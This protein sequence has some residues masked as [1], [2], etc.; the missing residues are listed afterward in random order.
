MPD[1]VIICVVALALSLASVASAQTSSTRGA[2]FPDGHR[3]ANQSV[4]LTASVVSALE[5]SSVAGIA[6]E[7]NTAVAYSGRRNRLTL[8]ASAA[9]FVRRDANYFMSSGVDFN[10]TRRTTLHAQGGAS[11]APYFTLTPF[12]GGPSGGF[13]D[14]TPQDS[15]F[16]VLPGQIRSTGAGASMTTR[17]TD[18]VT[19]TIGTSLRRTAS[20]DG[21]VVFGE[22]G[23]TSQFGRGLGRRAHLHIGYAY[24][25]GYYRTAT[26]PRTVRDHD[27]DVG[28]G[29]AWR[30]SRSRQTTIEGAA[31][32]TR[33]DLEG[34]L[35]YL[36]TGSVNL[37]RQLNKTWSATATYRRGMESITA[38]GHAPF[39]NAVSATVTGHIKD[40]L[41][42]DLT[43]GRS[44]G[45]IGFEA[46]DNRYDTYSAS[47]RLA[48]AVRPG[49][50]VYG[51][52]FHYGFSF[53]NDVI[54]PDR[55][56]RH[57]DRRGPRVGLT[58]AMPLARRGTL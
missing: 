54:L 6:P 37:S 46:V 17:L 3:N 19:A 12:A 32:P 10:M 7:V 52:Y 34:R 11:V 16:A 38:L 15:R 56:A 27:L 51:E 25:T 53:G 47:A 48:F 22:N 36:V 44:V 26:V 42:F 31:G 45:Q 4:D 23:A 39:S 9:V 28:M 13:T 40:P 29:W 33:I 24:R 18:R 2:L 30:H 41:R 8:E 43:A 57:I 1:S 55:Y 49:L 50:A 5:G 58:F 35:R 20:S 21:A 14:V